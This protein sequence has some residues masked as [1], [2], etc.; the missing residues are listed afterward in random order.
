M[1]GVVLSP[2]TPARTTSNGVPTDNMRLYYD[3]RAGMVFIVSEGTGINREG[4]W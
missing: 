3:E 4:P 1:N 2:L